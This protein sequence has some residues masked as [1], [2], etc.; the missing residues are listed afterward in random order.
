MKE[1]GHAVNREDIRYF[2]TRKKLEGLLE[3]ANV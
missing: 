2:R 1:I 3:I